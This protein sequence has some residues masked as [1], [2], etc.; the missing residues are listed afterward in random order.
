MPRMR[1]TMTTEA[2]MTIPSA[3]PGHPDGEDTALNAA[4][5]LGRDDLDLTLPSAVDLMLRAFWKPGSKLHKALEA[6]DF[7]HVA[8]LIRGYDSAPDTVRI[9]PLAIVAGV[10]KGIM[11]KTTTATLSHDN[12]SPFSWPRIGA[13]GPKPAGAVRIGPASESL[14]FAMKASPRVTSTTCSPEIGRPVSQ[15][16]G[17]SRVAPGFPVR[18]RA[19]CIGDGSWTNLSHT[20]ALTCTRIRSRSRLRRRAHTR[21]C[22]S[23]ARSRTQRWP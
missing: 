19:S 15:Y 7:F 9:A 1:T 4:R 21:T 11:L 12:E 8:T 6:G 13:D 17:L 16:A 10:I 23:M 14:A 18:R 22:A 20:W 5:E 2:T 3:Y